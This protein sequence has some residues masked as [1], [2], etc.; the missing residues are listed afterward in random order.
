M[1]VLKTFRFRIIRLFP[2]IGIKGGNEKAGD[3][4]DA[5]RY[6][7]SEEEKS[8]FCVFIGHVAIEGFQGDHVGDLKQL[9][10]FV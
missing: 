8:S 9:N 6:S 2:D 10:I 3:S 4:L 1:A 5:T 7:N